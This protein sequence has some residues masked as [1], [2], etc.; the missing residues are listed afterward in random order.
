VKKDTMAQYFRNPR[1]IALGVVVAATVGWWLTRQPF[2]I[3][4]CIYNENEGITKKVVA[5]D[6]GKYF[7]RVYG[8]EGWTAFT[9]TGS[10][11]AINQHFI[12]V[13][14]P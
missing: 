10:P 2:Q 4:E 9:Q 6:R 5:I 14:C 3:G 1:L 7:L 11:A 13:L 8:G 12:K